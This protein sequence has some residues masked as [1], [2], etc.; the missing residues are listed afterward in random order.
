[1]A[2]AIDTLPRNQKPIHINPKNRGKFRATMAK[3]GETAHQ[4]KQS[5]NPT[6]AKRANFA[7][8]FG[9]VK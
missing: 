6:T 4:L 3:T 2:G 1:M 7:I 5:S 9:H 8:N